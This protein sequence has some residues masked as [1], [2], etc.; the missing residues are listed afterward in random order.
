M[1]PLTVALGDKYTNLGLTQLDRDV[2]SLL[3]DFH[4]F[5]GRFVSKR[6]EELKVKYE[7]S[8]EYPEVY[9]DLIEAFYVE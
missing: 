8:K 5:T 9:T 1:N 3:A 4:E 2:N 7:N 6:L